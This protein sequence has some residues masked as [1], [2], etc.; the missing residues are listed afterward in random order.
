MPKKFPTYRCKQSFEADLEYSMY[1]FEKGR[2][3]TDDGTTVMDV[4]VSGGKWFEPAEPDASTITVTYP[5]ARRR[6]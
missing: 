2:T 6:R 3:Y 1:R 5:E 4:Y